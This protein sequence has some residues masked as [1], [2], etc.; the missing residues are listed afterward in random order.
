MALVTGSVDNGPTYSN[1]TITPG[2]VIPTSDV[3]DGP[4]VPPELS[5]TAYIVKPSGE[6]A[7]SL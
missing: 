2:F 4:D 7:I 3:D 1:F 5:V 6:I